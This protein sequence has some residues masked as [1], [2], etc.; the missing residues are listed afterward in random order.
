[1]TRADWHCD[2]RNPGSVRVAEKVGFALEREYTCWL[3]VG[4]EKIHEEQWE[5]WRQGKLV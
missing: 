3:A 1:M 2:P 5:R 4:D